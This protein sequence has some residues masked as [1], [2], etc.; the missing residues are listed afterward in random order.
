MAIASGIGV[1]PRQAAR[2]SLR[3]SLISA[4]DAFSYNFFVANKGP[5]MAADAWAFRRSDTVLPPLPEI[6]AVRKL[7]Y[8]CVF[9]AEWRRIG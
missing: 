1:T 8:D 6:V 3:L 5:A 2:I 7:F 9:S 4:L